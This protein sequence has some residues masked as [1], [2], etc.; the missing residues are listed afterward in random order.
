MFSYERE[1]RRVSQ[2]VCVSVCVPLL[3][4]ALLWTRS[5]ANVSPVCIRAQ[6]HMHM[7]A[8]FSLCE[9]VTEYVRMWCFTSNLR[10]HSLSCVRLHAVCA[11]W[12][13]TKHT[14]KI[15]LISLLWTLRC[16]FVCCRRCMCN[17]R[18]T[19]MKVVLCF[20]SGAGFYKNMCDIYTSTHHI[21]ASMSGRSLGYSFVRSFVRLVAH[22]HLCAQWEKR[23]LAHTH[24]WAMHDFVPSIHS[25]QARRKTTK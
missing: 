8:R 23:I 7:R 3:Y 1:W 19:E 25:E 18:Q 10:H 5:C 15:V 24:T 2:C 14:S 20:R 13:H 21:G 17:I 4:F 6:A 12:H 22:I 9:W 16:W 11:L